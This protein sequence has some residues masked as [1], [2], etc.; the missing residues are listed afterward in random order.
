[1]KRP[2]QGE[3]GTGL[4][5]RVAPC[6]SYGRKL[7]ALP[8]STVLR[9]AFGESAAPKQLFR[10]SYGPIPAF[11]TRLA[12]MVVNE[13]VNS[14]APNATLFCRIPSPH[15]THDI[16]AVYNI[17]PA[18]GLCLEPFL[19]ALIHHWF[20]PSDVHQMGIHMVPVLN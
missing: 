15:N 7:R 3:I 8:I 17:L 12:P 19:T 16:L 5:V 11:L 13:K 18:D 10:P 6:V 2:A 4:L 14:T 1:M 9:A 20:Q